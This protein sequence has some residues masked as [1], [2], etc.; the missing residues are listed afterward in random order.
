MK[1]CDGCDNLGTIPE[2]DTD[3]GT[4]FA[5]GCKKFLDPDDCGNSIEVDEDGYPVE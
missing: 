3:R 4:R 2:Y 5:T 1:S